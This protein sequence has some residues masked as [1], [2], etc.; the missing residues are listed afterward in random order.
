MSKHHA[1]V[2]VLLQR[3]GKQEPDRR[4]Q[5]LAS[6]ASASPDSIASAVNAAREE[7]A[8]AGAG[9][10]RV[11]VVKDASVVQHIKF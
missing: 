1:G 5:D 2:E 9:N 11:L 7:L 6:F 3:R 4:W 8:S 10:V